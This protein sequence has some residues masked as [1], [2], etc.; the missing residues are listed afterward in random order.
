MYL[1]N[2][3]Y[4]SLRNY[5]THSKADDGAFLVRHYWFF[6]ILIIFSFISLIVLMTRVGR[7]VANSDP[8]LDIRANPNIITNDN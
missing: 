6:A 2:Y 7:S 8:L 3:W 4:I 5:Q 1:R